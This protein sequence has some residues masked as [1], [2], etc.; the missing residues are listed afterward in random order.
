MIA[1]Q[2]AQAGEAHSMLAES[3]FLEVRPGTR[4]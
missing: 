4:C 3:A 2:E 1:S